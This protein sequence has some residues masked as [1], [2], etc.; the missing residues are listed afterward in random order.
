[1]IAL[2]P[3]LSIIHMMLISSNMK[4]PNF[5]FLSFSER[6]VRKAITFLSQKKRK[7][8]AFLSFPFRKQ[9]ESE[10]ATP[11]GK[12]HPRWHIYYIF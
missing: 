1:M 3:V 5:P 8:K 10:R 4:N 7:A 2:F 6:K 11:N 12:A 9:K